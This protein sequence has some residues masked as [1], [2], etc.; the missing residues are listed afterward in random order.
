MTAEDRIAMLAIF[1]VQISVSADGAHL[2]VDGPSVV[3]NAALPTIRQHKN[4][5]RFHLR[6]RM[7][8]DAAA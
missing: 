7:A 5:L 4:E 8:T 1:G 6:G 2:S 3:V